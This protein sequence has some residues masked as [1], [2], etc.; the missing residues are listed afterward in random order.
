MHNAY[1]NRYL[2]EN[3]TIASDPYGKYL[4]PLY[5]TTCCLFLQVLLAL[6]AIGNAGYGTSAISTLSK[7]IAQQGNPIEIRLSAIDA[8]RRI[9]CKADVR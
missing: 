2:V 5:T 1:I 6:R 7:C 8:F 3:I 9:P 4:R